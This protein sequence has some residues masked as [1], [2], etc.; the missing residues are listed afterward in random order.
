MLHGLQLA[1]EK[2][3]GAGNEHQPFGI[4]S[5]SGKLLKLRGGRELVLVSA[6]KQLGKGCVLQEGIPIFAAIS[7]GGQAQRGDCAHV[8]G[9]VVRAATSEES[10]GRAKAE[11][12]YDQGQ[13]EFVFKPIESRPHIAGFGLAVMLALAEPRTAKIE[14]QHRP[15]DSGSLKAFMAW[16]TT[17]LCR[18]PPYLG[19]G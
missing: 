17:L 15:T 1:G 19:W 14:A 8:I 4:G 11:P 10:H 9:C 12:G 6:E 2:V 7:L 5:G 3:I 16:Y 13:L 18:L